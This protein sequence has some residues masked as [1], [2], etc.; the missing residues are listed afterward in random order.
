[1]RLRGDG[2]QRTGA[3]CDG[4]SALLALI[5]ISTSDLR[6][7]SSLFARRGSRHSRAVAV[8]LWPAESVHTVEGSLLRGDGRVH[9][10]VGVWADEQLHRHRRGTPSA[11]APGR[12]HRGGV[13]EGQARAVRPRGGLSGAC[14]AGRRSRRRRCF[15]ERVHCGD[16]R[17]IPQANRRTV[18]E[19]HG[20]DL[21]GSHRR[22]PGT[23]TTSS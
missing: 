2:P 8:T 19:L 10:G 17:R 14:P 22:R 18:G 9:A 15:L 6:S 20:A 7:G 16:R 12:V 21:A 11:R 4:R 3:R 13:L 1:M 23:A 5:S